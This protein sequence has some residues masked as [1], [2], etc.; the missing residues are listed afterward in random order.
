MDDTTRLILKNQYRILAAVEK[1]KDDQETWR[2]HVKI[3]ES[4]FE[5]DMDE[6]VRSSA[7]LFL[8]REGCTLVNKVL[9]MFAQIERSVEIVKDTVP[10]VASLPWLKFTGFDGNNEIEYITYTRY[11]LKDRKLYDWTEFAAKSDW[12]AHMPTVD[13]YKGMV[14]YRDAIGNYGDLTAEELRAL[15]AA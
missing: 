3:F 8:S 5:A 9:G 14:A 2:G 6:I 4:G 15:S 7:E 11:L 10:D 12:N 13:K 1:N